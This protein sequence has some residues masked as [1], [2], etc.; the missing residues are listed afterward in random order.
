MEFQSWKVN[1]KTEVCSKT[2]NPQMT[3]HWINYVEVAKSIDEFVTSRSIMERTDF[4]DCD[5]LDVMIASALKKLLKQRA[6]KYNRFLRGR[7]IA[8]MVCEFF[9]SHWSL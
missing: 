5:M 6:Q 9:W 1:F 7:Q 4:P 2:A 8:H 3:M